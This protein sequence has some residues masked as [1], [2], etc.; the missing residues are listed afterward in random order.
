[1]H[2]TRHAVDKLPGMNSTVPQG[3]GGDV[4]AGFGKK[5]GKMRKKRGK[6]GKKCDRK[7]GFV[8]MVFA[9]QNPYVSS[10]LAELGAQSM[11]GLMEQLSAVVQLKNI[12]D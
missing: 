5:C 1:M 7:C 9:P 4:V 2:T 3:G 12:T 6:C 11:D 8:R 10:R